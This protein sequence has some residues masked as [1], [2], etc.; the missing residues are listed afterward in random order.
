[1]KTD[2]DATHIEEVEGAKVAILQANWHSGHTDNIVEACVSLLEK[3]KCEDIDLY[4]VPGSYELPLAAKKLA[5]LSKYDAIV[6]VGALIKGDTDHYQVILDTCVRELGRVM[7]D[8]EVPIIMEILPVHSE[9]DLIVR[10]RG[11]G[12]KGIEAALAVSEI[13]NFYRGL[14]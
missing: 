12:N 14:C 3:A 4:V 13:V 1:M 11:S 6:V 7:Y 5:K 10:T 9:E 8:Y 2:Y